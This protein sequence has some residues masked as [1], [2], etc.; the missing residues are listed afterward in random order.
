MTSEEL[1]KKSRECR[2]DAQFL[3]ID[4][5]GSRYVLRRLADMFQHLGDVQLEK[6]EKQ[7]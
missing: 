6:E 7:S 1:Y 5:V 2:E 4:H 3:D